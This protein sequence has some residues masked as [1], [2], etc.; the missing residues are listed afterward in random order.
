MG[1]YNSIKLVQERNYSLEDIEITLEDLYE[2]W[3][4][5]SIRPEPGV[6]FI[7]ADSFNKVISLVENLNGS[8]MTTGEIAELFGFKERQS[9]YYFNACRYLGLA[10]KRS[11]EE[12]VKVHIT[13]LGKK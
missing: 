9:D 10:E 1:Y 5:T 8:P 4:K 2:T 3:K 11:G 13:S 12:G 7:Q 6:T